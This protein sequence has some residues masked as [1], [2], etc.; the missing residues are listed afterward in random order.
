MYQ[1][2]PTVDS[3]VANLTTMP[4]LF[5]FTNMEPVTWTL[6]IEML[7]YGFLMV[8]LVTGLLDKPLRTMLVAITVCL[9]CC[10][11]FTWFKSHI[12]S[13]SG[14]DIS[15]CRRPVL[16]AESA[17]VRDGDSAQR[18]ALQAG[19]AM[20]CYGWV[21]SPARIVFHA[22]DLRDHNPVATVLMFGL[23]T[24]S[25]FGKVPMLRWK[26]LIYIS[27]ISYSLYL[28]HNNLGSAFLRQLENW[29]CPPRLRSSSRR[30]WSLVLPVPSLMDSSSP[31][32]RRL[33]QILGSSQNQKRRAIKTNP[34]H[35]QPAN[36]VGSF[37]LKRIGEPS[38]Y[39]PVLRTPTSP[40]QSVVWKTMKLK[41]IDRRFPRL[42][43][44]GNNGIPWRDH[45]R[46]FNG[47]GWRTGF[48]TWAETCDWR[49]WSRSTKMRTGSESRPGAS[50]QPAR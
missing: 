36:D 31:I 32:T 15:S 39:E 40:R 33:Q 16:H 44:V 30:R 50:T 49:F 24:A 5:G 14:M 7:F 22:I 47:A 8:L 1:I 38:P 27:F 45:S 43:V 20:G 41:F 23:L 35:V 29:N 19:Q 6:Q 11:T 48:V 21:S 10:T 13:Q 26:P 2:A 9:I 46:F 28:F 17:A 42:T 4:M 18:T 25:A 34:D 3:T 12:P 37:Q